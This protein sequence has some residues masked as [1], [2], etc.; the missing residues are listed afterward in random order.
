MSFGRPARLFG[1]MATDE[2]PRL[3]VREEPGGLVPTPRGMPAEVS[4]IVLVI[5]GPID[6]ADIPALCERAREVLRR[7]D[8]DLVDCDLRGVAHPDVTV[9]EAMARL[10]LTAGRTGRRIRFR[11]PHPE[12]LWLLRVT[13]MCDVLLCGPGSG[14]VGWQAEQREQRRG[15]EKEADPH[16]AAT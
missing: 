13:G 2:R 11:G 4:T 15:V 16:D 14:E 9:V 7:C 8:A 10:Q 12:L 3:I 6:R 1:Q 5:S